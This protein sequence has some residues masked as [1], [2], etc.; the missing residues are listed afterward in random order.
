[1]GIDNDLNELIARGTRH[2]KKYCLMCKYAKL[3]PM[4]IT[5]WILFE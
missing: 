1:M 4:K 3:E 5:E 2:Y